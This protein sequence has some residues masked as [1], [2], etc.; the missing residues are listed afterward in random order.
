MLLHSVVPI[1]LG[2][3]C[4]SPALGSFAGVLIRRLPE[5]RSASWTRSECEIC[6]HKLLAIDVIPVVSF[7]ALRGRCRSC[8][9]PIAIFHLIIEVLGI[10]VALWATLVE[11]DAV[12]LWSTCV[13]GWTL[14][15]MGWIDAEHMR[16]PNVLT[17]PLTTFG[18]AL[19]SVAA[20]EQ[21]TESLIGTLAGYASFQAIALTYRTLRGREGLGAGDAKLMAA[22]GAWIGWAGLPD[23][24]LLAALLAILATLMMRIGPESQGAT[25]AIPFGP[26]LAISFWLNYLY[27]PLL[28]DLY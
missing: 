16:L 9:A 15:A 8:G 18:I 12:W 11:H 23:V 5:S 28:F 22:A 3:M 19:H 26:F 20:P 7:L 1:W 17:L 6:K 10:T 21:L 25:R 24:A 27:G 4:L 13:L 2:P 14:L